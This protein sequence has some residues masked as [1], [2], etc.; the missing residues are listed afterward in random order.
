ME[1]IHKDSE[2]DTVLLLASVSTFATAFEWRCS[3]SNECKGFSVRKGAERIFSRQK[4]SGSHCAIRGEK[5]LP[6]LA[7]I[8]LLCLL[9]QHAQRNGNKPEF[10]LKSRAFILTELDISVCPNNIDDLQDN[11]EYLTTLHF[12]YGE[13]HQ[14]PKRTK[15]GLMESERKTLYAGPVLREFSIDPVSKRVHVN[16][17]KDWLQMNSSANR[18]Q[19]ALLFMSVVR[20]LKMPAEFNLYR[21][22]CAFPGLLAG[23]HAHSRTLSW[24]ALLCGFHDFEDTD[25]EEWKLRKKVER[26]IGAVG[27]AVGIEPTFSKC[28]G[29]G[30][31]PKYEL[32]ISTGCD[33]HILDET[34]DAVSPEVRLPASNDADVKS[35]PRHRV[36]LVA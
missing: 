21:Y 23:T 24:W 32:K 13:A 16:L 2:N 29:V 34:D 33:Q 20:K 30:G 8:R 3:D 22:L 19:F 5:R 14:P 36:R 17:C 31:V 7:E 18:S 12:E 25:G 28:K 15:Y 27:R 1:D 4:E 26:A 10:F 6:G 35:T 11:L 9:T